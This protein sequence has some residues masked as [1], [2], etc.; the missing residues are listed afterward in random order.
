[1]EF[2]LKQIHCQPGIWAT[3]PKDRKTW[4][5]L[6]K[7]PLPAKKTW[8][9]E[10]KLEIWINSNKVNQLEST[11]KLSSL[12]VLNDHSYCWQK[13]N[14]KFLDC[15]DPRNLTEV[16]VNEI[17]ELM[18]ENKLLKRKTLCDA[19][20]SCFTWPKIKTD[21]KM[22]FP[23]GIQTVEIMNV[24]VTLNRICLILSTGRHQEI[25]EWLQRK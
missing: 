25:K 7:Q 11:T 12:V 24:I 16:L 8:A 10:S 15:V 9:E 22:N 4:H 20:R 5:P 3:I 17:N 14:T 19:N 18:L 1:M 21:V 2:Q 23:T 13:D 6:F